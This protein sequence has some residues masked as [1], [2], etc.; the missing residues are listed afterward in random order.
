ME[1][2]MRIGAADHI[3]IRVKDVEATMAFY[4]GVLGLEPDRLEDFRAEKR[5]LFAFRVNETFIL[6][7]FPDPTYDR[8]PGGGYDHLALAVEG[9]SPAGL[10]AHLEEKGVAIERQMEQ[11][12]GARGDGWACYVRDPDGYRVELKIYGSGE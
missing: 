9:V 3:N 1:R 2:A 6:H 8:K 11:L 5:P 10:I 12:W 4:Q 7:V